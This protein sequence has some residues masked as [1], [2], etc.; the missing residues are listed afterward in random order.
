MPFADYKTTREGMRKKKKKGKRKLNPDKRPETG[1][2]NRGK[3][4]HKSRERNNTQRD[5]E[6]KRAA[7][8]RDEYWLCRLP[9]PLQTTKTQ[10][11]NKLPAGRPLHHL[12]GFK[13]S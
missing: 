13:S 6:N 9:S 5:G 12:L 10:N 4:E 3:T 7:I 11:Q 8:H 2:K 1:E